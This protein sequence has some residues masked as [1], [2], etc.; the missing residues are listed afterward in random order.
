MLVC[1]NAAADGSSSVHAAAHRTPIFPV[2]IHTNYT[3]PTSR[4]PCIVCGSLGGFRGLGRGSRL[5]ADRTL[6]GALG[7]STASFFTVSHSQRGYCRLCPTRPWP[8]QQQQP[9][10]ACSHA[11]PLAPLLGLHRVRPTTVFIRVLAHIVLL[12]L[13][14]PPRGGFAGCHVPL[15]AGQSR[16]ASGAD[17]NS[18]PAVQPAWAGR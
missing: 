3:M 2:R 14:P 6:P 18:E 13:L 8:R 16:K 11:N 1:V 5:P 10:H 15:S 4:T 7:C 17:S 12:P 9:K